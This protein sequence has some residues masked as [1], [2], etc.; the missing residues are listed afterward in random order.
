M[1][2]VYKRHRAA[3]EME[4]Y[5]TA[6]ELRKEIT[7]LCLNEKYFPKRSRNFYALPIF[8]LVQAMT[9]NITFA[10]SIF[11]GSAAEAAERARYQTLAICACEAL[12]QEF[13]YAYDVLPIP[14]RIMSPLAESLVRETSLLRG[15]KK[16]DKA[17]FFDLA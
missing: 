3:S 16:K 1:S 12:L 9:Q 13:Q 17:R 14:E 2:N 4:F 8:T 6:M 10:N 7:R 11:P 5:N 15:W